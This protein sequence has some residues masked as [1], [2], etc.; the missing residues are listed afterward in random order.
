LAQFLAQYPDIRL[1]IAIDSANVDI[2]AQQFD[3]GIRASDRIDRDM[4]AV[5]I[6]EDWKTAVVGAP[7]YLARRGKPKAPE[8]LL[9]HNCIRIR[10]PNGAMLPWRFQGNGKSYTIAVTGSLILNDAAL[11]SPALL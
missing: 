5:K 11:I 1:E 6:T 10:L 8:D 2:V 7:A 3:A 4:I 9:A